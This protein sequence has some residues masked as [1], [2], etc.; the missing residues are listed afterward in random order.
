[1]AG[2][3]LDRDSPSQCQV[4]PPIKKSHSPRAQPLFKPI[5]RK[6]VAD[7]RRWPPAACR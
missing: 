2:E 1:V 3:Q 7:E 5:M 4:Y 6:H